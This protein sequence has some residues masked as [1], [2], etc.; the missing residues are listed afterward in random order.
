V[1]KLEVALELSFIDNR[2]SLN[3]GFY[4]NRTK[5]QLVQYGL[6]SIAGFNS[7]RANLPAIIEN[8]GLEIEIKSETFRN[9][10]FSWVTAANLTIPK[11]KLVSYPNIQGSSYSGRFV[12]GQP[13]N[14]LGFLYHYTGK[15]KEGLY[16]FQDY[17]GDGNL[18]TSQ[19]RIP[20]FIGQKFFGG[21]QNNLRFKNLE[22]DFLIQFT[23]QNGN[24]YLIEGTPGT[25]N[26]ANGNQPVYEGSENFRQPYTQSKID[27]I[28]K[29]SLFLASD[30]ILTDASFLRLKNLSVSYQIPLDKFSRY[31]KAAKVYLQGQNLFTI[32]NYTGFD[33]EQPG[34][35]YRL[36]SLITLAA[37]FR[38]SF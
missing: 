5:N 3:T 26:A 10:N 15:D 33:P 27:L 28:E 12:I 21:I 14:S 25:F 36:P 38:A 30:G 24:A 35:S 18:T 6:P 29:T 16:T 1:N 7:V 37:G 13:V 17:N 4:R 34:T 2:F 9:E 31:I 8:S 32:S 20:V 22:L 19:D 23:K 11:N